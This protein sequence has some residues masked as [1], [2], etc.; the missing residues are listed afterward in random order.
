L[1]RLQRAGVPPPMMSR[2]QRVP[3]PSSLHRQV[4]VPP[5]KK[6]KRDDPGGS[7]R[8]VKALLNK[9]ACEVHLINPTEPWM[10]TYDPA[11]GLEEPLLCRLLNETKREVPDKNFKGNRLAS[12]ICAGVEGFAMCA[13]ED[14]EAMVAAQMDGAMSCFGTFTLPSELWN[15][16]ATSHGSGAVVLAGC[17]ARHA[18]AVNL[19]GDSEGKLEMKLL[20]QTTLRSKNSAFDSRISDIATHP[21]LPNQVLMAIADGQLQL[22]DLRAH[23]APAVVAG[24]WNSTKPEPH[25]CLW[26]LACPCVAFSC[27]K[28]A[29]QTVDLRIRQGVELECFTELCTVRVLA[30]HCTGAAPL[31]SCIVQVLLAVH[32][33]I[34]MSLPIAY[35]CVRVLLLGHLS[36]PCRICN[37]FT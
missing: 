37:S 32:C 25:R 12:W 24:S 5:R 8:E 34:G 26:S 20:Q 22:W 19:V 9:L 21:S 27:S 28:T 29:L 15:M 10:G 14:G 18:V 17:S 36:S 30:M 4:G 2:P 33:L 13:G 16:S 23:Q 11:C 3:L 6:E 1:P 31:L 7:K 35:K